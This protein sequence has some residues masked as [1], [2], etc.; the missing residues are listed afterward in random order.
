MVPDSRRARAGLCVLTGACLI[1]GCGGGTAAS[2]DSTP[3]SAHTTS[4]TAPTRV[5]PPGVQVFTMDRLSQQDRGFFRGVA[6]GSIIPEGA[7]GHLVLEPLRL[8]S[9]DTVDPGAVFERHRHENVEVVTMILEG[10]MVHDGTEGVGTR[11]E[12]GGVQ[13]MRAG[14]GAEHEER[15]ASDEAPFVGAQIWLEPRNTDNEP[16]IASRQFERGPDWT[17][18]VAARDAPLLVDA[19][20]R[21]V[22]VQIPSGGSASWTVEAGRTAYVAVADGG[23]DVDGSAVGRYERVIVRRV[24]ELTLRSEAGA[25]VLLVDTPAE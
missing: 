23:I 10:A 21:F 1:V 4:S 2:A 14:R 20:I 24:G 25:H 17:L 3:A 6:T 7:P 15:N 19:D 12:A 13:V 22:Q 9:F 16:S 11:T 8:F 18:M 5:E